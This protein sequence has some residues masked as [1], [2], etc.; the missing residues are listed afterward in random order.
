MKCAE[1]LCNVMKPFR[2]KIAA[3]KKK[4]IEEFGVEESEVDKAINESVNDFGKK[5]F[6]SR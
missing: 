2:E 4:Y 3:M 6:Y 5:M 1:A